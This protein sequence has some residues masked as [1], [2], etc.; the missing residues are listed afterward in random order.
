[1]RPGPL[2]GDAWWP[3]ASLD[4][5]QDRGQ[6]VLVAQG[7]LKRRP[8]S[9]EWDGSPAALAFLA[10][11]HHRLGQQEQARAVLARLRALLDQ[12]QRAKD[13]EVLDLMLEAEALIAPPRET[14]ER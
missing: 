1:M 6:T 4:R 2:T 9:R 5:E 8:D 11:A 12:P 10:M 14:T 7:A 3:F 13:A